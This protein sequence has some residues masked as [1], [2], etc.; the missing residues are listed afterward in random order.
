MI[1]KFF[2]N[3]LETVDNLFYIRI[4]NTTDFNNVIRILNEILQTFP[5]ILIFDFTKCP[6]N[7]IRNISFQLVY[8]MN[9]YYKGPKIYFKF[10]LT[11]LVHRLIE[12]IEFITNKKFSIIYLNKFCE[13][14]YCL[15]NFIEND[16][17]KEK[18]K[19]ELYDLEET[20]FQKTNY[21]LV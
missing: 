13:I 1:K 9:A 4:L 20:I 14:G 7:N 6:I 12:H 5:M 18:I 3:L 19:Q 2:T 8:I 11:L 21:E 16:K 15:N 17:Q 10:K